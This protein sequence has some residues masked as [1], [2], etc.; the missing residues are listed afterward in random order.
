MQRWHPPEAFV[1]VQL[2]GPYKRW[3]HT[4]RF[5]QEDGVT[6]IEDEV[7]YVLEWMAFLGDA[8]LSLSGAGERSTQDIAQGKAIFLTLS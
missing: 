8:L 4:H 5:R 1:D 2:R 3:I 7:Q 6:I